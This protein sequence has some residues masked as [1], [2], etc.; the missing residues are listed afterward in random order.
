MKYVIKLYFGMLCSKSTCNDM[1]FKYLWFEFKLSQLTQLFSSIYLHDFSI[2]QCV[3]LFISCSV[4]WVFFFLWSPNRMF[5]DKNPSSFTTGNTA[6]KKGLD[7]IPECYVISPLKSLSL[8]IEKARISTIDMSR[9]QM[10]DNK[11]SI[12]IKELGEA[13]RH[14]GFFQVSIFSLSFAFTLTSSFDI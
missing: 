9:L 13:C 3:F 8:G 14:R 11:R 1:H 7:Y 12:T 10:N 2:P 6:K 4:F 5:G